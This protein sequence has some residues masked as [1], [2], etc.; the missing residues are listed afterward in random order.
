MSEIKIN[1]NELNN[2]LIDLQNL[3]KKSSSFKENAPAT[4]GGGQVVNEIEKI[5]NIYEKIDSNVEVMVS[6]TVQFLQSVRDSYISSDAK[7]AR[8]ISDK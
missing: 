1:V 2:L 3:Q 4:I 7:A 6:N 8:G 5:K